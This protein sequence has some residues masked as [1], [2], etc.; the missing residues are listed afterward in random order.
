MMYERERINHQDDHFNDEYRHD[1]DMMERGMYRKGLTSAELYQGMDPRERRGLE[2][3]S[4]M[5]HEDHR[6]IANLPQEVMIRPYPMTGPYLPEDLD[7]TIRGVDG[8]MD[9]DDYHRKMHF[10]PKKH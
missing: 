10:Y 6:A 4:S 5:I 8:Q 3:E 1:K 7:D 2:D 9:Y